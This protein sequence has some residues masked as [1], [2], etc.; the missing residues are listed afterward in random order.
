MNILF[1]A[2]AVSLLVASTTA[3]GAGFEKSV[4]ESG[5][6]TGIADAASSSVWG[7]ESLMYNPAGLAGTGMAVSGNFSP[8]FIKLSAPSPLDPTT[9]INSNTHFFP[10]GSAFAS[11]GV[12]PKLGVAIGWDVEGGTRAFHDA[13]PTG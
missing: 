11:Y 3:L 6:Y 12:T 7:P 9:T 1:N 2:V 13:Y 8:T 4:M 10:T 5:R